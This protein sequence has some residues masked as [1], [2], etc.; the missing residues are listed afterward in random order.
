MK[1]N[2]FIF[3][4]IALLFFIG[5]FSNAQFLSPISNAW[6]VNCITSSKV[7]W[8]IN[9]PSCDWTYTLS[10]SSNNWEVFSVKYWS[11]IN[12]STDSASISV[13]CWTDVQV[14]WSFLT[15]PSS[16]FEVDYV[17][18]YTSVSSS[19]PVS[20]LSPVVNWL[21]NTVSEFIP[22]IVYIWVWILSVLI[23]FVAIKRLINWIRNKILSP[24]R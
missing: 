10:L 16:D 9:S 17:L 15:Y 20:S 21:S 8:F 23:W 22:Y 19:M 1:K 2:I 5:S 24:F 3:W 4:I 12:A 7:C 13:D 11:K 14:W 18:T 6:S